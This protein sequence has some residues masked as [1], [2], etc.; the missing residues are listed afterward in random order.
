MATAWVAQTDAKAASIISGNALKA[1]ALENFN[2]SPIV[3]AHLTCALILHLRSLDR[4]PDTPEA[5][6]TFRD[7]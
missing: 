1:C 5:R 4:C 6:I 7:R 2:E 3:R